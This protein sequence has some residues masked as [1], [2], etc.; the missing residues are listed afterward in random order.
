[1]NPDLKFPAN[2]SLTAN[3]EDTKSRRHSLSAGK[4]TRRVLIGI[5]QQISVTP[6]EL[7]H[8]GMTLI[9]SLLTDKISH[10]I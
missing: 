3:L 7:G 4:A 8:T 6:S 10:G 5:H 2:R 1:M 9:D